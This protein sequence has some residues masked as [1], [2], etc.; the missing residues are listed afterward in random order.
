M[1]YNSQGEWSIW[2]TEAV[3]TELFDDG[4]ELP[5]TPSYDFNGHN[6]PSSVFTSKTDTDPL[7]QTTAVWYPERKELR[8]YVRPGVTGGLIGKTD[9]DDHLGRAI[10]EHGKVDCISLVFRQSDLSARSCQSANM[11]AFL[12]R[13]D[14]KRVDSYSAQGLL[15]EKDLTRKAEPIPEPKPK[16]EP[17]P[18]TAEQEAQRYLDA[19]LC[20]PPV[21]QQLLALEKAK[22][23]ALENDPH[24]KL[25][26]LQ[27]RIAELELSVDLVTK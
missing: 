17:V 26:D 1:P 19:G 18:V 25:A 2:Q 16:S 3:N 20:V 6:A 12:H 11:R 22:Q 9:L 23:D 14:F 8:L 15:Y 7:A 10:A 5:V 4:T 13:N 27:K 24:R 21:V